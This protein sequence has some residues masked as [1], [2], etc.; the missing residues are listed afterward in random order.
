MEGKLVSWEILA[1]VHSYTSVLLYIWL[2]SAKA[3]DNH[4]TVHLC[5]SALPEY[6]HNDLTR[7][8]TSISVFPAYLCA[9]NCIPVNVY[10]LKVSNNIVEFP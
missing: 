6:E 1:V 5:F 3:F 4:N 8:F 7:N 2:G 10:F 9:T